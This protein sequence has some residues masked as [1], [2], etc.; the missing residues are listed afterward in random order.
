MSEFLDISSFIEKTVQE[1][2]AEEHPATNQ[3]PS[4]DV[5]AEPAFAE[6]AEL[7]EIQMENGDN[8]DWN[9]PQHRASYAANLWSGPSFFA[10]QI[11]KRKMN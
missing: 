4:T 3:A 5:A 8:P 11:L 10:D 7:I 2:L 1:A 6:P 9:R